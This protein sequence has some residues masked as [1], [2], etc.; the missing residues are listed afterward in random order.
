MSTAGLIGTLSLSLDDGNG[1]QLVAAFLSVTLSVSTKMRQ[2]YSPKYVPGTQ[3]WRADGSVLQVVDSTT[4]VRET[5]LA[6]IENACINKTQLD[7]VFASPTGAEY[8]SEGYI[9]T[10]QLGGAHE[11][12]FAGSF[13]VQGISALVLE[14]G[15]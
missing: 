1:G 14:E 15:E 9:D 5:Y 8:T 12:G 7:V 2:A 4:L 3:A 13:G 10:F 6:L 11:E